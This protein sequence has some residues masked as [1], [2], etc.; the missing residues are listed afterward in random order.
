M[1]EVKPPQTPK[2]LRYKT[3]SPYLL[4]FHVDSFFRLDGLV[5]AAVP[6]AAFHDPT[7]KFIHDLHFALIN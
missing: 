6:P 2:L 3:P 4:G 5:Q 7:G 1:N